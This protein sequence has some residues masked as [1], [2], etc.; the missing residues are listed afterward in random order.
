MDFAG[1][2]M[3]Y[4]YSKNGFLYFKFV[5]NV[6]YQDV[7]KQ[8]M[9]AVD[10]L[11]PDNIVNILKLHPYH[12]DSHIQLSDMAKAAEDMQVAA[13]LIEGAIHC[14]E[15]TFN[16]RFNLVN[17]ICRLEYKYQEN[18]SFFIL[19][20]KHLIFVGQR[21]CHRTA[22]ELCKRL[23]CLDPG[24]DPLCATLMIDFYA[25]KAGEAEFLVNMYKFWEK[26]RN[27]DQLPNFSYSVALA[28]H[29]LAS[30][31]EG[32]KYEGNLTIE[33]LNERAD[34]M[35]QY[36]L[37]MF[38]SVLLPLMDKLG[39]QMDTRARNHAYFNSRAQTR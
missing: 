10:S 25:I 11:N 15:N 14:L 18:R 23:L 21:A 6:H 39:I 36:A 16:A 8:F 13:E 4:L 3:S 2:S 30:K 22:L 12:V 34:K 19:L 7:Q 37:L 31:A 9:R 17:P 35:I 26:E 29:L 33:E 27:L 38:P 24:T 5:H 32:F 20:F 28:Y 1:I